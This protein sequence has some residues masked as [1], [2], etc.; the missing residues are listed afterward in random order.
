MLRRGAPLALR[1]PSRLPLMGDDV[2]SHLQGRVYTTTTT[3]S[4]GCTLKS[5]TTNRFT[6]LPTPLHQPLFSINN[7][8]NY[9]TTSNQTSSTKP[10]I[11]MD[12]GKDQQKEVSFTPPP[13]G[14]P[15]LITGPPLLTRIGKRRARRSSP[16]SPLTTTPTSRRTP[17]STPSVPIPVRLA[18][19]TCPLRT[20]AARTAMRRRQS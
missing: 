5:T 8:T 19:R 9:S 11:T 15:L 17:S 14:V 6:L 18:R 4:H 1:H 10:E 13:S 3:S 7:A 20:V 12:I 16:S 2:I